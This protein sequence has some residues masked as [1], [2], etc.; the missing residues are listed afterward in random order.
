MNAPPEIMNEIL[1]M[2]DGP[3]RNQLLS[4]IALLETATPEESDLLFCIGVTLA[5]GRDPKTLVMA[6]VFGDS[7]RDSMRRSR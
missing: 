6:H 2:P 4:A 3:E 5:A 1:S 7:P